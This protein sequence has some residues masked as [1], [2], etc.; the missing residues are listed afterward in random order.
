MG[1]PFSRSFH[2]GDN[3]WVFHLV[4]GFRFEHEYPISGFSHEIRLVFEMLGAMP[5]KDLELPFGGLEP[6]ERVAIKDQSEFS[7]RLGIKFLYCV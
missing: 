1:A 7:F 4:A 5:V 3:D 6:F 2:F